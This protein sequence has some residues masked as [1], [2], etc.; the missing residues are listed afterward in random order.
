MTL[1]ILVSRYHLQ[2]QGLGQKEGDEQGRQT[3]RVGERSKVTRGLRDGEIRKEI[4]SGANAN[5][6]MWCAPALLKIHPGHFSSPTLI[7]RRKTKLCVF[8]SLAV[9][10]L[11]RGYVVGVLTVPA[12]EAGSPKVM[13][14]REGDV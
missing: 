9:T 11:V 8:A 6:L 13:L 14:G 5:S 4:R 3:V 2:T 12:P 10:L 7:L 1:T